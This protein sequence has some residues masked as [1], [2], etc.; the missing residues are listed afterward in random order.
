MWNYTNEGEVGKL[1]LSIS[2]VDWTEEEMGDEQ[3]TSSKTLWKDNVDVKI[4]SIFNTMPPIMK[5]C[6]RSRKTIDARPVLISNIYR[7]LENVLDEARSAHPKA[8]WKRVDYEE[9][10]PGYKL[11]SGGLD[12]GVL[13][14]CCTT[15]MGSTGRTDGLEKHNLTKH[16]VVDRIFFLN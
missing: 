6:L 15:Q 7:S 8:E 14:K 1:D 4:R 9:I 12:H 10:C 2:L 16:H 5:L 13:A 11:C 3:T